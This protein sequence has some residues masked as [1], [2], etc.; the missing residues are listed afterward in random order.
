M[1][2]KIRNDVVLREPL[3]VRSFV[4]QQGVVPDGMLRDEI[5]ASWRRS[6]GHGRRL[7]DGCDTARTRTADLLADHRLFIDAATP[8]IHAELGD[9]A[10]LGHA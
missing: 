7:G 1:H 4:R 6:L 3:D 8:V 5:D 9:K 2:T 10:L